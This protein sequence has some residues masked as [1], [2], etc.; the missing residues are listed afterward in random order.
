M[1]EKRLITKY[2]PIFRNPFASISF[3]NMCKVVFDIDTQ[4]MK[5]FFIENHFQDNFYKYLLKTFYF[6]HN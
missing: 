5:A 2:R 4:L 1:A 3:F 6:Q